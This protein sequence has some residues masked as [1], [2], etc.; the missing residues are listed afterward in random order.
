MSTDRLVR[1]V[2]QFGIVGGA[3]FLLDVGL[4][5]LLT[6]TAL[7]PQ[8]VHGGPLVAKVISTTAA[9]TANWLGNRWLTFRDH[10]RT[11]LL[12]EAVEFGLV[13][14]GGS[15]I[16]VLCLGMTHYVLHHTSVLADNLSA[17]VLGLALGSAFRFVAYR[18]WVYGARRTALVAEPVA[19]PR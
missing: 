12:R 16:A 10:R 19:G 11:D 15:L 14:I 4:F 17:N 8:S 13:S 6:L 18:Y 5:N 3:G 9:I 7:S 2:A 1:Q